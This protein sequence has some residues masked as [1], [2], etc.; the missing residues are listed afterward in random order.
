MARRLSRVLGTASNENFTIRCLDW[1]ETDGYV[2]VLKQLFTWSSIVV[3]VV[4]GNN[5]LV[6]LEEVDSVYLVLG[7]CHHAAVARDLHSS[8]TSE[9][10]SAAHVLVGGPHLTVSQFVCWAGPLLHILLILVRAHMGSVAATTAHRVTRL[11]PIII[12]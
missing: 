1:A 8:G 10:V 11:R 6:K 2:E 5:F 4:I 12:P 3:N 7:E 9:S